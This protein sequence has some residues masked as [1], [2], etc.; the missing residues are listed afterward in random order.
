MVSQALPPLEG[1]LIEAVGVE[2]AKGQPVVSAVPV[3]SPVAEQ[4]GAPL[5]LRN[6]KLLG[7]PKV[8]MS[9]SLY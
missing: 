9:M 7:P 8:P 2:V 6:T 3:T 1:V 5:K 4:L